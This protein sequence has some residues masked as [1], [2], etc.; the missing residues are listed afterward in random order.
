MTNVRSPGDDVKVKPDD[1]HKVLSDVR[2]I[3]GKQEVMNDKLE[4]LKQ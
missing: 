3:R 1:V 4:S 2:G